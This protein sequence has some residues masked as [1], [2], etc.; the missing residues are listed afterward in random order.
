[1]F[2]SDAK[3]RNMY[4]SGTASNPTNSRQPS[5]NGKISCSHKISKAGQNTRTS[6]Q[7]GLHSA[8]QQSRLPSSSELQLEHLNLKK[9][10]N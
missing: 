4:K 10:R 2:V 1:M 5:V 6:K 3:K 7:L 8:L 9:N